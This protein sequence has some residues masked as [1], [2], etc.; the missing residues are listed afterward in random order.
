MRIKQAVETYN[1]DRRHRW[2]A[3]G[4]NVVYDYEY[5]NLCSGCCWQE[6][7]VVPT[8]GVGCHECGYTG[9]RRDSVPVPARGPNGN[10]IKVSDSDFTYYK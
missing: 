1:L 8:I 10:L 7:N 4:G 6:E 5:T 9:K 2:F 3:Y